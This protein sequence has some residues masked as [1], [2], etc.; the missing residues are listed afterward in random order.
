MICFSKNMKNIP[1]K[2]LQYITGETRYRPEIK[3]SYK[4]WTPNIFRVYELVFGRKAGIRLEMTSTQQ[5]GK[6][7]Y[8]CHSWESSVVMFEVQIREILKGMLPKIS[9]VYIPQLQTSN[10]LS[11]PVVNSPYLFAIAFDS[12]SANSDG[13]PTA[14]RSHTVT[15]SDP[16]LMGTSVGSVG[17]QNVSAVT[18][19]STE[20][21]SEPV[22]GGVICP[23]DRAM[24]FWYRAAPTTG[25][26]NLVTTASGPFSGI[27]AASYS[28][29]KQTSP[30]DSFNSGTAS[31]TTS[32]SLSTTVV[33]SGCWLI[34]STKVS[35]VNPSAGSG[36]TLRQADQGIWDSN[37]TVGTGSQSLS[38]TSSPTSQNWAGIIVS[39]APAAT[40]SSIKTIDGLAKASVKTVDGL[41]IASVKSWNGLE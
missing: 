21:M 11:L 4:L 6:N 22:A 26:H 31:S 15:G 10:G 35:A 8:F 24:D 36:T 9:Y 12:T 5:N 27:N 33:A 7:I 28:G 29:V 34:M 38:V 1:L 18:W 32:F 39:I 41:A 2:I 25:T 37:G 3:W 13:F 40:P 16:F 20:S 30:I 17:S 23:G 19:N 14:T